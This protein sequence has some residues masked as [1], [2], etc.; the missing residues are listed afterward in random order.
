MPDYSQKLSKWQEKN[1]TT[2][3]SDADFIKLFG[4]LENMQ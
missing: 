3:K 1:P 2:P 4:E